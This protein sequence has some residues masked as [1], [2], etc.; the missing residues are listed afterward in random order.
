MDRTSG[1]VLRS[2]RYTG[3]T[4]PPLTVEDMSRYNLGALQDM[5][6][7]AGTAAPNW[8]MLPSGRQVIEY[9]GGD[10]AS[11]A[12]A[13][14]RDWDRQG[15]ILG[16]IQTIYAAGSQTI[17]ATSDTGTDTNFLQ[18]RIVDTTGFLE[19]VQRDGGALN[20]ITGDVACNDGL[21]HHCVVTG[22]TVA[23]AYI[24]Y[25][26]GVVQGLTVTSGANTGN[27]FD[28]IFD[29][30]DNLSVGAMLNT[31]IAD[32]LVGLASPPDIT[33]YVM[34]PTQVWDRFNSERGQ[35]GR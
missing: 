18:L 30:R 26:D 11:V 16:W 34:S 29:I 32:Y 33:Q 13:R 3:P 27:W 9:D 7:A 21:F 17:F 12:F 20:Q 8:D 6:F 24:L 14:W 4:A 23:G 10:Y 31:S 22:D 5:A 28:A 15:T 25:V 1:Y 19:I 35:F 2:R